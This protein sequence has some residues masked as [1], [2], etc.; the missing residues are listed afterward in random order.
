[1]SPVAVTTWTT[2]PRATVMVEYSGT[3]SELRVQ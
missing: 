1:M 2:S 3:R